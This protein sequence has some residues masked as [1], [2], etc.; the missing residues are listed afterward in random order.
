MRKTFLKS[1]FLIILLLCVH[2]EV[3]AQTVDGTANL[4]PLPVTQNASGQTLLNGAPVTY[5]NNSRIGNI[6]GTQ[7]STVFTGTNS[8]GGE[9]VGFYDSDKG[10][11]YDAYDYYKLGNLSGIPSGTIPVDTPTLSNTSLNGTTLTYPL[12]KINPDGT[13]G[14][15]TGQNVAL[16]T[17]L[18]GNELSPP[19][20]LNQDQTNQLNNT[21]KNQVDKEATPDSF[22]CSVTSATSWFSNCLAEAFYNIVLTPIGYMMAIAGLALDASI[23][24]SILNI[25][26]FMTQ[27]QS[28]III[29]WQ[30]LRDLANLVF[31]G[32]L[33]YVAVEAVIGKGDWKKSIA[34]IIIAALLINFSMFITEVVIDASN[35]LTLQFYNSIVASSATSLTGSLSQSS[36]ISSVIM[37][38]AKITTVYQP[39]ATGDTVASNVPSGASTATGPTF[40]TMLVGMIMGAILMIVT[41][42]VF[43]TGA[44][45]FII[46][47]VVLLVLLVLSPIAFIGSILPKLDGM[48][49]KKW[50]DALTNQAIFAPVYMLLMWISIKILNQIAL[51]NLVGQV[52]QSSTSV[53]GTSLPSVNLLIN[54]M[55]VIGFMLASVIIAAMLGA[56]GSAFAQKWAGAATF[57]AAGF[58]GR[59]TTGRLANATVNAEWYKNSV[60]RI[61][62]VG[63]VGKSVIG[64]VANSNFDLRT[65]L[66]AVGAKVGD[67]GGKGGYTK[68]VETRVKDAQKYGEYLSSGDKT[69]KRTE[70]YAKGTTIFSRLQYGAKGKKDIQEKVLGA[71]DKKNMDKL[72]DNSDKILKNPEIDKLKEDIKAATPGTKQVKDLKKRLADAREKSAEALAT[73]EEKKK[74]KEWQERLDKA[75]KGKNRDERKDAIKEDAAEARKEEEEK[76]GGGS[77]KPAPAESPKPAPEH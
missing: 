45:L 8:N 60:A 26:S 62:I 3:S 21:Q 68:E 35:I 20:L 34:N 76:G 55:I 46:R 54:F 33:I 63:K 48:V 59:N 13:P 27:N 36:P 5:L 23:K 75:R 52:N 32:V 49:G 11:Y 15:L 40:M 9:M 47:F 41:S 18:K 66:K 58:I 44:I 14:A 53:I 4:T 25:G 1:I 51:S 6:I 67:A 24:Y 31:I 28:G 43:L 57:G 61:P 77:S 12:A 2:I 56:E 72:E 16:Q 22:G 70:G 42:F 74:Y 17:D 69:G 10:T 65:P 73:D 29:A 37:E 50:R 19:V 39:A 7:N 64:G 30:T 38:D 71:W